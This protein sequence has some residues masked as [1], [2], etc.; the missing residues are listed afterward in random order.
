[1]LL[2]RRPAHAQT[3]LNRRR[4]AVIQLEALQIARQ[5]RR[6]LLHQPRLDL[7][8]E[9]MAVHQGMRIF[10][11]GL[12]DFRMAVSQGRHV[13][14]RRE[15]EVL[16]SVDVLEHASLAGLK[17][18]RK[19]LHLAA[20]PLEVL[21][22][23]GVHGLGFRSWR[24]DLDF[25]KLLEIDLIRCRIIAAHVCI[26]PLVAFNNMVILDPRSTI[27]RVRAYG[28][29]C[30][31]Q[32]WPGCWPTAPREPWNWIHPAPTPPVV[33]CPPAISFP[34]S[35]RPRFPTAGSA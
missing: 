24:R 14:A 26:L 17:H 34:S 35:H 12:R 8:G 25:R 13:D 11:H 10:R 23:P 18:H 32:S 21:G 4:A 33:H 20:E 6:H 2:G 9:I 28:N 1:M 3:R 19:Q 30:G 16:I 27:S 22:A 15:I 5:D 7:G 31:L 29:T